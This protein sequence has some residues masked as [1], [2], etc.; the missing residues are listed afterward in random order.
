M[1]FW[2]TITAPISGLAKAVGLKPSGSNLGKYDPNNMPPEYKWN[3]AAFKNPY[4]S[5]QM[6]QLTSQ[7]N[8]AQDILGGQGQT[9]DQQRDFLN[10]LKMQASG[11]GVD[12]AE[13]QYQKDLQANQA[14]IASQA[15][16]AR[17]NV[18]PG[19]ALRAALNAQAN[20]GSQA[21]QN[22][23]VNRATNQLNSQGLYANALQSSRGQDINQ[24]QALQNFYQQQFAQQNNQFAA[25]QN[26]ESQKAAQNLSRESIAAGLAPAGVSAAQLQQ[27]GMGA[28]LSG[29]G[30]AASGLTSAFAPATAATGT[31]A[32]SAGGAGTQALAGLSALFASKGGQVGCYDKGGSVPGDSPANDKIH[33]MLSPGEI[34]IPRS[35]AL[36]DEAPQKSKEFVAALLKKKGMKNGR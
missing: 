16:S 1:G 2:S 17:G 11:Q 15:A 13:A 22:A 19:M 24:Q 9:V 4:L 14:A 31:T 36:S 27:Q 26:L 21:A 23:A 20:A 35:I 33:V 3:E 8:Q 30:A 29:I 18:D 5:D 7:E 25:N 32:A 34:V 28:T 6:G 10:A 12:P